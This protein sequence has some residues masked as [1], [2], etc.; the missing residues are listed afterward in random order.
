MDALSNALKL[1]NAEN[2]SGRLSDGFR[3]SSKWSRAIM[4]TV[5]VEIS[6]KL[7]E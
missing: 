2:Q 3:Q 6:E 4:T 7:D 5:N 1:R